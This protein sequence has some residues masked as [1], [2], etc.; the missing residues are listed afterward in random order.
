MTFTPNFLTTPV[1]GKT[2]RDMDTVNKIKQAFKVLQ[3]DCREV[4]LVGFVEKEEIPDEAT[5]ED[6]DDELFPHEYQL[7]YTDGWDEA[8]FWGDVYLPLDGDLYMRFEVHA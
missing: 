1:R 4:A 5:R 8:D 6:C 2:N 3:E 7:T